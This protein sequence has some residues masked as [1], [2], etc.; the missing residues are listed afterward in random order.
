M[1]I[2]VPLS[3]IAETMHRRVCP[4]YSFDNG[5]RVH[6]VGSAIPYTKGD[7]SF[8]ITASHVC[9]DARRQPVALFTWAEDRPL[10]LRDFRIS[11]D[12]QQGSTPDADVALLALPKDDADILK[13]IYW[14]SD[15]E[16]TATVRRKAPGIHY[17]LAG[18]PSVRNRIKDRELA[19]PAL[20]THLITGDIRSVLETQSK[21]KS[22]ACHF[23]L[24]F[25]KNNAR[26]LDGDSF[27][28][29]K[30]QGMSGGGVWRIDLDTRSWEATTPLLVG[31]GIEY[32]KENDLF[33]A[34]QIQLAISLAEDLATYVKAQEP[35]T[36]GVHGA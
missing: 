36:V 1:T 3:A 11:W 10:A 5:G 22:D 26:T 20:A 27:R 28:V 21:D 6:L 34:T 9:F 29:P 31:V 19:P 4:L 24:H 30:P 33:V 14:F 18:Y 35:I 23:V 25:P 16:S 13:R 8:L 32:H 7:V 12:Y 2:L 17:L 15:T